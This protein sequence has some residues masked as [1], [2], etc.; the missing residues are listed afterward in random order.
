MKKKVLN[1][2]GFILIFS[3][4]CFAEDWIK[5]LEDNLYSLCIH[6]LDERIIYCGSDISLYKTEDKGKSWQSI[7]AIGGK[8]NKIN[9][10]FFSPYD[11]NT[12]YIASDKG[13]FRS[14]D[15]G[16]NFKRI[17]KKNTEKVLYIAKKK[18]TLFI[19]TDKSLYKAEEG[20]WQW[21]RVFSLPKDV[22]V[23]QIVFS[24]EE[25]AFIVSDSGVYK[26]KDNL[27]ILERIFTGD[28][29]VNEEYLEEEETYRT[30]PKVIYLDKDKPSKIYLGTNKGLFISSD[31]NTFI[32]KIFSNLG[33]PEINWIQKDIQNPQFIY[34]ATNKGFFKL[35]LNEEIALNLH[36]GLITQNIRFFQQD[37]SGR[38]WLVTDKGLYINKPI[39]SES[40]LTLNNPIFLEDEPTIR[41]VQEVALRYNEIHPEKIKAWRN[42]LRFRA[43]FP[44][45]RIDYDKNVRYIER[46]RKWEV[47]PRDWN[48]YLQWDLADLIWNPYQDD[49]DNRSRLNTQL[50]IDILE[51]VNRIYFERQRLKK[52]ME[53]SPPK[54]EKERI[55]RKLRLEELTALLDGYTGGIFSERWKK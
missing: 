4:I 46:D 43:L 51:E 28:R 53:I 55:E 11:F 34:L 5:I 23:R 40:A 26:S 12:L 49:V 16:K 3:Q 47:G 17:F 15:S 45:F 38:I 18:T 22:I 7:Y 37:N 39:S 13:L 29:K 14:Q 27:K 19:A 10:I 25:T 33:E 21:Q 54:D 20:I 9:F 44:V 30:I 6:P 31:E 2:V 52:L 36:Q 41:E 42:S 50:R 48:Y 32:K 1:S 35:D 8:S 24:D